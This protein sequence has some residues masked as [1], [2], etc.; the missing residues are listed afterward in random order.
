MDVSAVVIHN[1]YCRCFVIEY[2]NIR[3]SLSYS[4]IDTLLSY[5]HLNITGVCSLVHFNIMCFCECF[6]KLLYY[7]A[8]AKQRRKPMVLSSLS[9]IIIQLQSATP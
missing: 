1:A 8:D 4:K 6:R 3:Q 9:F 7:L 2:N 5:L